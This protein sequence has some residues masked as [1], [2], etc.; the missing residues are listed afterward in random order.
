MGQG[1]EMVCPRVSGTKAQTGPRFF[2]I[3][4]SPDCV[5]G[6]FSEVHMAEQSDPEE[7]EPRGARYRSPLASSDSGTVSA[8][9]WATFH[10]PSSRR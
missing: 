6:V 3:V 7:Q 1:V 9:R 4:Y 10:S 5:E 8:C 2:F